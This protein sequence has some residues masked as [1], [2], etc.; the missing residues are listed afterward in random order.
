MTLPQQR[1][2]AILTAAN[3]ANLH[4]IGRG[5]LTVT[6]VTVAAY[7]F[8]D[9]ELVHN[10]LGIA[11]FA[12]QGCTATFTATTFELN[13]PS[14]LTHV[15]KGQRHHNNLWRIPMLT[16]SAPIPRPRPTPIPKGHALSSHSL[17]QRSN[18]DYVSF[19]HAAFGH[20]APTTFLKAAAKGFIN[21]PRQYPRLTAR[22]VRKYLPNSEAAA[23]GHLD[24][25]PIS[26]PHASSQAV[27]AL[28]RHHQQ[29]SATK[30]IEIPFDP[31]K[32]P[33]SDT[34]HLDYTGALSGKCT[35][36]VLYFMVTCWGSYIHIEPLTSLRGAQT[37]S[38]LNHS[39]DFF[40]G[41]GVRLNQLRMQP[42]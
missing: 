42:I 23:R 27:S 39:V 41:K 37:A 6:T 8:K 19:V 4:A 30:K 26:R 24:Q 16:Q 20:P 1:P 32:V 14:S 29:P 21:G 7:I 12:D 3:G 33:K 18:Q 25:A 17:I 34:L 35:S 31:T 15:M 9:S 10:L 22:L 28:R 36:G 2:F 11:P 40:R 5:L 13:H 38:A